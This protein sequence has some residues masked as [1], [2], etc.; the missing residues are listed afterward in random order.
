MS[1]YVTNANGGRKKIKQVGVVFT[2]G[3][4]SQLSA[5]NIKSGVSILGISGTYTSSSTLGGGEEPITADDVVTGH[6]GWVDGTKI[7]GSLDLN[8]YYTGSSE[9]SSSLGNDGDIYLKR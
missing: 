5:E 2:E 6:S 9:P 3:D 7:E 8:V 4:T 1:L